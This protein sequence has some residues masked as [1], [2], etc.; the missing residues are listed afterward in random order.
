MLSSLADPIL[1]I[2]AVPVAGYF[3]TLRGLLALEDAR[4]INR[5]TFFVAVPALV[6]S[7][8]GSAQPGEIWWTPALIYLAAELLVYALI[9][10]IMRSVFRRE[11][12]EALLLGMTAVFANHILFVLPIAERFYPDARS[13]MAGMMV[14]DGIVLFCGSVFLTELITGDGG[15]RGAIRRLSSNPFVYAVPLGLLLGVLGPNAPAG[16]WTFLDFAGGTAAP[17]ALFT[18][19]ITLTAAPIW[20][21]RLPCWSVSAAKL[22]LMPGLVWWGFGSVDVPRESLDHAILILA[23]AG[24]CG[25][26]PFVIATQYAV[27][28]GTIAKT[29]FV[30]TVLSLISLALLLP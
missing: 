21:I 20:P 30:S 18:L 29:I 17:V 8:I 9:F 10:C 26:M 24:P 19:G 16:I 13:G 28:T 5:Y 15:L 3:L 11:K 25:A 22:L 23:A 14:L 27:P 7:V 2:F 6:M 4:S 1:P 12:G